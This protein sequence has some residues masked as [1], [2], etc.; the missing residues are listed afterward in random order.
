LFHWKKSCS[1]NLKLYD[2]Y[3]SQMLPINECA[4]WLFFSRMKRS[5]FNVM[6]Y[7]TYCMFIYSWLNFGQ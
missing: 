3:F 7:K 6:V 5:M 1:I 4:K 2:F